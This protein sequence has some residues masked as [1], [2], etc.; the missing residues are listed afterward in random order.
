M[1]HTI[2][3]HNKNPRDSTNYVTDRLHNSEING[4]DVMENKKLEDVVMEVLSG[5][6]KKNFKLPG[7]NQGFEDCLKLICEIFNLNQA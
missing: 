6:D 1:I 5:V 2:K 3:F 4:G 7:Y